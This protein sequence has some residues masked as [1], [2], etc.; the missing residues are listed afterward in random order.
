MQS[1]IQ[2]I[3]TSGPSTSADRFNEIFNEQSGAIAST[4]VAFVLGFIASSAFTK[5]IDQI[6]DTPKL[7]ALMY[8]ILAVVIT[9]IT[10]QVL[11][12][13]S[14]VSERETLR[15]SLVSEFIND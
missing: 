10:I 9:M 5:V 14:A 4:T 3:S 8:V 12:M 7:N 2:D 11:A 1:P 13:Q 15:R 6:V